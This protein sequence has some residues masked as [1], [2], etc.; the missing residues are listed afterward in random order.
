M[1]YLAQ[2]HRASKLQREDLNLGESDSRSLMWALLLF[3]L[4]KLFYFR[5][6]SDLQKSCKDSMK[7]SCVYPPSTLSLP[8]TLV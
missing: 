8:I 1:W 4:N 5:M 6:F 3:V 7:S 2:V